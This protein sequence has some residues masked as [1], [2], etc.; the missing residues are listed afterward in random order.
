MQTAALDLGRELAGDGEHLAAPLGRVDELG[1]AVARVRDALDVAVLL[2]VGDELGHRLLADLCAFGE[3][4][5]AGPVVVEELE[6]VPVRE[7]DLRVP[8]LLEPPHELVAHGPERL[9]QQDRQVLRGPPG[10]GV[11]KSIDLDK[12]LAY[13]TPRM[14]KHLSIGRPDGHRCRWAGT[15]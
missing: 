8:A 9:P 1:P 4:A 2:E 12:L 6:D 3:H 10:G 7:A 5:H 11:G 14:D 13:P 15:S